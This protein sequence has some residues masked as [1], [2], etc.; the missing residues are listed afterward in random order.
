M[1]EPGVTEIDKPEALQQTA[2][3]G[4]QFPN[5]LAFTGVILDCVRQIFSSSSNIM[6]PQL[7]GYFWAPEMTSDPLK[8]PYQLVIEDGF[9]FDLSKDGI[10]PAILVEAG[11]WTEMRMAIGDGGMV[12]DVYH[13]RIKGGHTV[14]VVG[15]TVSQAELIAREVQGYLSHFGPLLREW[16]GVDR[17]EV[18]VLSSPE[19]VEEQSENVVVQ[20]AVSYEMVYAWELK[21]AVSR[22]LRQIVVNAIMK[23]T[24]TE[25][26]QLGA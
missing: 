20:I 11:Q 19:E 18:P 13:K 16:I 1:A 12:G 15:K 14:K 3:M 8:A 21:P 6:H 2:E 17:W 4:S 9:K 25:I 10:R 26:I 22:L 23:D 24:G 5:R 7:E